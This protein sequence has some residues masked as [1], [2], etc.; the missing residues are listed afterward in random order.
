MVNGGCG[1]EREGEGNVPLQAE[2]ELY[3]W[4]K[5]CEFEKTRIEY[6]GLVISENRVE[7]DPVKVAGV[8]EWPEPMNK[9]EVQSFLGFVNFYQRFVKDFL[10][11]A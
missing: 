5:K 6:L 8:A 4:P 3:L 9:R 1:S 11:H 10:H 2:H 7:M